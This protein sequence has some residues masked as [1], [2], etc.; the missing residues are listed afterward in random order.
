MYL[1]HVLE[2]K[3]EHIETGKL[4]LQHAAKP[5]AAVICCSLGYNAAFKMPHLLL[6]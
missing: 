6:G 3:G 4:C 1:L 2:S 5:F